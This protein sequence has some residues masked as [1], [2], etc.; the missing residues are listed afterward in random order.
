MCSKEIQAEFDVSK[1]VSPKFLDLVNETVEQYWFLMADSL[2]TMKNEN[3]KD[4]IKVLQA[5]FYYKSNK[6][7]DVKQFDEM[8]TLINFEVAEK[9]IMKEYMKAF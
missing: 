1:I 9:Q 8:M 4:L 5:L 6:K 7:T 3:K 2:S